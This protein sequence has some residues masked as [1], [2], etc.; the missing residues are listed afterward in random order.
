MSTW[1]S[2]GTFTAGVTIL[3]VLN[4]VFLSCS[5]YVND[6]DVFPTSAAYHREYIHMSCHWNSRN[7]NMQSA[8]LKDDE[9]LAANNVVV[10]E[11]LANR[12]GTNYNEEL[13]S[14]TLYFLASR[15]D[16][17]I[18][19]CCVYN[20]DPFQT[21]PADCSRTRSLNVW[22]LSNPICK[23]TENLRINRGEEATLSCLSNG[24]PPA[25]LK[26]SGSKNHVSSSSLGDDVVTFLNGNVTVD[27]TISTVDEDINEIFTCTA[28]NSYFTRK[29][30]VSV[31]TARKS[32]TIIPTEI[33]AEV[34]ESVEFTCS[35]IDFN[36]T[37]EW[38]TTPVFD[39]SRVTMSADVLKI[40]NITLADNGTV[41]Y[42]YSLS[43]N[44]WFQASAVLYVRTDSF[45][46]N[47]IGGDN[48]SA[49]KAGFSI[50]F[51]IMIALI[52]GN[53]FL[54]WKFHNRTMTPGSSTIT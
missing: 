27:L 3:I 50:I 1:L 44:L 32:L 42:C 41:I 53:V 45:H 47:E 23:P 7:S 43:E 33:V 17:G 28:S 18:Y 4:G 11:D 19:E 36:P 5:Q 2:K 29:C 16:E 46:T 10:D 54:F 52:P 38:D 25:S 51:I 22:Y 40:T 24:N 6:F 14:S 49:W 26:W 21:N 37:W 39:S 12:L 9:I 8:I 35:A 34:N 30:Q 15:D 48:S 13:S 20:G 31:T